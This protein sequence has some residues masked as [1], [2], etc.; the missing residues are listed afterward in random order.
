MSVAG[1]YIADTVIVITDLCS[2]LIIERVTGKHS[3]TLSTEDRT[4]RFSKSYG[5][6]AKKDQGSDVAKRRR[7]H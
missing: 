4:K 7:Q 2:A 5:I 6:V 1:L 3:E